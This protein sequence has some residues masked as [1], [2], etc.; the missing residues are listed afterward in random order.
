MMSPPENTQRL[1]PRLAYLDAPAAI[2]FL[3]L[4]RSLS[5]EDA[6]IGCYVSFRHTSH[7]Q[8]RLED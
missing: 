7:Y 1:M 4:T 3:F 2:E 5:D 6:L 8:R